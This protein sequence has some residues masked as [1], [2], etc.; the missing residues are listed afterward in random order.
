MP[1][2]CHSINLLI[3][4]RVSSSIMCINLFRD[5]QQIYTLFSAFVGQWNILKN[6]V[7]SLDSKPLSERRLECRIECIKAI[8]FEITE[9]RN[10][11]N[12]LEDKILDAAVVSGL[13]KSKIWSFW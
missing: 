10:A 1:C 9:I 11:L 7:K 8:M 13:E 4:D 2:G 6:N 12:E 3:G 5:I